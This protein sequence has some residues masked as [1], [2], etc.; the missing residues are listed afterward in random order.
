MARN[1]LQAPQ[2]AAKSGF[3]SSTGDSV[4]LSLGIAVAVISSMFA[5]YM[6]TSSQSDNTDGRLIL[7]YLQLQPND[8]GR[9]NARPIRPTAGSQRP[10]PGSDSIN[11]AST[12]HRPSD[13]DTSSHSG[14]PVISLRR[15]NRFVLLGIYADTALVA[16]TAPGSRQL[17]P[18]KIG[19]IVPGAGRVIAFIETGE[20]P[21]VLTTAGVISV[22]A[23]KP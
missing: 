3:D 5:G 21:S 1:Q 23:A 11:T 6:W 14:T 20:S 8:Q 13:T 2:V 7:G 12:V 22:E 16:G 10:V 18:V 4:T 17:W 9:T 15:L 19:S